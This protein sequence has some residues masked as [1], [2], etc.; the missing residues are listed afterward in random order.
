MNTNDLLE[1]NML[2]SAGLLED[3]EREAFEIAFEQASPE[4]QAHIRDESR[5]MAD[6]G[7]LV[8]DEQPRPELRQIILSAVRAAMLEQENEQRIA[9]EKTVAGTIHPGADRRTGSRYTQPKL[10]RS[11]RVHRIWRGTSIGLAAAVV[12]MVV[13]SVNVRQTYNTAGKNAFIA[14]IYDGFGG[15][16]LNDTMFDSNTQRVVLATS[17]NDSSMMGA[18]VFANPDWDTARLMVK[19]LRPQQGDEEFRLVVLDAEGNIVR[20]VANFTSKGEIE[21]FD[22]QINLNTESKL[23]IYQGMVQDIK[24]AKPLMVSIDSEM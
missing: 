2:F 21:S 14:N 6:L 3:I 10:S 18:S 11:P 5:R 22:I 19:N 1:M 7:D 17:G 20:E 24:D 23:A 12:A 4:V 13:V 9:S 15:Q 8:Q 16:F